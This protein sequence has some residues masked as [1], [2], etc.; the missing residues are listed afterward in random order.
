[1]GP[2]PSKTRRWT[3][4]ERD[5]EARRLVMQMSEDPAGDRRDP[6]N[7]MEWDYM[8]RPD[9]LDNIYWEERGTRS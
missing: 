4:A 6:M 2:D 5:A 9:N 1:M 8:G 7:P 3:A